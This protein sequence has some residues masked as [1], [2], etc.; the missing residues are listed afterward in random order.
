M[1]GS[2]TRRIGKAASVLG[3][4]LAATTVYPARAEAPPNLRLE[5]LEDGRPTTETEPIGG[6]T[7][8]TLRLPYQVRNIGGNRAYAV[9]LKA[10]TTLGP[11]G[12]PE[13]LQ[14]GPR[15]G[16]ELL[17]W[18]D[19]P[20]SRGTREICLE[21]RLQTLDADDPQDPD[22]SDNRL[23]RRVTVASAEGTGR[24]P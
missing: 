7:G 11:L 12:K 22:P 9:L 14:P 23:C 2:T 18:V 1:H 21:A 13:R 19:L 10:Y 17:R 5:W 15:A 6:E 20:V 24:K 3:F 4:L 8:E 16:E